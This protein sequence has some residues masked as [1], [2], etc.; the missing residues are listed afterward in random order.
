M[1]QI[2]S[3]QNFYGNKLTKAI[4]KRVKV[5]PPFVLAEPKEKPDIN[6]YRWLRL[7]IEEELTQQRQLG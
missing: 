3:N 2:V 6:P 5:R 7:K 4:I 1:V